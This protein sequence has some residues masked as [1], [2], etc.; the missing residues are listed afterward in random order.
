MVK[1]EC[2]RRLSELIIFRKGPIGEKVLLGT[3]SYFI[4]DV[5]HIVV[6]QIILHGHASTVVDENSKIL[7]R[8]GI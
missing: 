8:V 6:L 1:V 2:E 5:F 3:Q 4:R 7:A